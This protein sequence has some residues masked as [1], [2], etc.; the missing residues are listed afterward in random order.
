MTSISVII[1]VFNNQATLKRAV[2][3]VIEVP[4]VSEVII[5]DDGSKDDS[6]SVARNLAENHK[7]IKILF[8]PNNQNRGAAAS[9]NLGLSHT[10]SD[11]IQFL[12]ADDE[13]LNGKL[14]GQIN[15]V[16]SETV[17]VVG[18]SIHVFPDGRRHH[19]KSDKDIWRGLIRSKLGDTCAN[20][21]NKKFL[22]MV[23]GWDEKLS[24]SQEY[25]L[26][27]RL[28]TR[29]PYVVFDKRSL[30]LIHKTENSISTDPD[31]KV[32]RFENWFDLRN[33]IRKHLIEHK[34]FHLFNKYYWSGAVGI[35]SDQNQM[36]LPIHL[37]KWFYRLYKLEIL[38]KRKI[39]NLLKLN[40]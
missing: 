24:S 14:E 34:Q 27:F 30:T 20:L 9:R 11:W 25:D 39:Y 16:A 28:I 36:D 6:L 10:I 22:L 17:I 31:K 23:G 3:S 12:D 33:K 37:N 29:Q 35:F 21:W 40:E 38:I 18:N 13:L 32:Q 1:P 19:R 2:L 8:H 5:V 26:M 4:V 15:L 7:K